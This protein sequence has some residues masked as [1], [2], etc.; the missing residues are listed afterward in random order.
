MTDQRSNPESTEKLVEA[1]STFTR[2]SIALE[3]FASLRVSRA[4][5]NSVPCFT[6]GQK[7]PEDLVLPAAKNIADLIVPIYQSPQRGKYAPYV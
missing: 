7:V 3:L 5:R 6:N 2:A 1:F 4:R